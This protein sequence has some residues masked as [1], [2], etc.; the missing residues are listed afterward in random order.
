MKKVMFKIPACLAGFFLGSALLISC[1]MLQDIASNALTGASKDGVSLD[2]QI[3][4]RETE[5]NTDVQAGGTKGTGD[6]S[7]AGNAKVEVNT[8]TSSASVE[9]AENVTVN[10]TPFW[11]V[12]VAI[13]GWILPTPSDIF[14]GI[15]GFVK[16]LK[17][18]R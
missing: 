3:G 12:I 8:E 6:V 1:S 13:L 17:R 11:L 16:G 4:D 9:E 15:L 5:T 18:K 10:N 7:A 2:A 14:K